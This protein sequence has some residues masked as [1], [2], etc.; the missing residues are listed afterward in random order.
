MVSGI[1]VSRASSDSDQ[2]VPSA[3][4]MRIA[5]T[6]LVTVRPDST[7]LPAIVGLLRPAAVAT[8]TEPRGPGEGRALVQWERARRGA[9]RLSSSGNAVSQAQAPGRHHDRHRVADLADERAVRPAVVEGEQ[10]PPLIRR[11]GA[12]SVT[13]AIPDQPAHVEAVVD[14]QLRRRHVERLVARSGR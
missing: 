14:E 3:N 2:S 10:R 13:A 6:L 9:G 1:W 12:G 5:V 4:A 8:V 11:V 7:A